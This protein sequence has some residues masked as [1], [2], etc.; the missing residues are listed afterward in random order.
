[1][2]AARR[3][4]VQMASFSCASRHLMPRVGLP[5]KHLT[6]NTAVHSSLQLKASSSRCMDSSRSIS[7][8]TELL[9]G[10]RKKS[11][12][13]YPPH[14]GDEVD[15]QRPLA[16]DPY[17]STYK[18]PQGAPDARSLSRERFHQFMH[19]KPQRFSK[20]LKVNGTAFQDINPS[21]LN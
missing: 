1:M 18:L 4:L 9:S 19:G 13:N 3:E 10:R 12:L 16:P 14:P 21:V 15:A 6:H 20:E 7:S 5:C 17:D 11:A 8:L 2:A